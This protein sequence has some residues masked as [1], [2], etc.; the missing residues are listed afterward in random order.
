MTGATCDGE[1]VPRS[2][3]LP[4]QAWAVSWAVARY[5]SDYRQALWCIVKKQETDGA[6]VCLDGIIRRFQCVVAVVYTNERF[7]IWLPRWR[8]AIGCMYF[9][10]AACGRR[11]A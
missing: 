5:E 7:R 6:I 10:R 4:A 8:T 3:A 2:F 9:R 1:S 11:Y